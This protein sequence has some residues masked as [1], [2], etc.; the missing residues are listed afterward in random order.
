MFELSELNAK[1]RV[2]IANFKV[3]LDHV[4]HRIP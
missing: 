4:S 1:F 2:F 3:V